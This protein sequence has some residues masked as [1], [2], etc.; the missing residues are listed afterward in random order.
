M[1]WGNYLFSFEGRINRA[2]Y[3]L[4]VLISLIAMAVA[5]ALLFALGFSVA[6]FIVAGIIYLVLLY[7]GLAVGAK[8]LHDRNKSGWW[9]LVFYLLPNVLSGTGAASQSPGLNAITGLVSFGILIW[10]IVEL[11]CL[12]GTIGPNQYGPDPL[13]GRA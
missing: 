9:L 6:G 10:A 1:D 8:R 5:F 12:R 4:F 2:K 3:W 7:C 11:G 13:E